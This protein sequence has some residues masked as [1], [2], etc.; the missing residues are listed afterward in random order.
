MNVYKI[1]LDNVNQIFEIDLAGT[2]YKM[3]V[4]YNPVMMCW[5]FDLLDINDNA[6]TQGQSLVTGANILDQYEYLGLG[7]VFVVYTEGDENAIPTHDNLGDI[8]NLYFLTN[9]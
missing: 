3:R 6:I 1:P 7:G 4:Y 5:C 2:T 9:N 8:S